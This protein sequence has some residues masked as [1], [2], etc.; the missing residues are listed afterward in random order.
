MAMASNTTPVQLLV[1][2]SGRQGRMIEASDRV[3][4]GERYVLF[5]SGNYWGSSNPEI[6]Y[7]VCSGPLSHCTDASPQ[8]MLT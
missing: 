3:E 5:C 2:D 6:G 1:P 7:A 4:T 8:P